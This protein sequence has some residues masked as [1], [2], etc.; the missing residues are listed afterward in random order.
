[1][2]LGV[3]TPVFKKKGS[4]L[5]AKHYGGINI[6]PIISKIL[7]SVIRERIKP[8]IM[9]SQNLLQQGF[10][11][12]SSPM[13]CSLILEEYIRNNKDAQV[14]TYIAFL[15]VKSVFD[16]VSHTSLLRKIC[17]TGMD[18][19]HW[20]MISSLHSNARTVIKRDRQLLNVFD[21]RKGV[22]LGGIVS[23]YLYKVY[24]THSL[25]D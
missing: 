6:T 18:S 13:N 21:I 9:E 15:D 17:H 7:E 2:T 22:Q 14:P 16:V 23:T 4:N 19:S 24:K 11:E 8:F 10:T 25:I 3:L 5:D 12:G 1:M 20:N